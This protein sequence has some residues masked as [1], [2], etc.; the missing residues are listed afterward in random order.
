MNTPRVIVVG[1]SA[2]AIEVLRVVLPA[3]PKD[4]EPSVV[5]V[6]HLPDNRPSLLTSIFKPLCAIPVIEI[7]DKQPLTPGTIFFA[8][9]GYHVFIEKDETLAVSNEDPVKWSRPSIDM[10]FVSA[11][12]SLGARTVAVLLTGASDDGAEGCVRIKSAGGTVI[13]QDPGRSVAEV[14]PKAAI[15]RGAADRVLSPEGIAGYLKQWG[16]GGHA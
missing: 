10:L 1:A 5:I 11:A 4:Y 8:P 6:V 12:E 2:G 14:M 16:R 7:D 15:D 9:P 13:V 3:L